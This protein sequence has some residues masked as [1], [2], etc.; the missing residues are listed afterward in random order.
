[1]TAFLKNGEFPGREKRQEKGIRL[2]TLVLEQFASLYDR[3]SVLFFTEVVG[4]DAESS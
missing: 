3:C 2:V 1:M 4:I